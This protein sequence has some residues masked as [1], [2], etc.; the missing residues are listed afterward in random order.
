LDERFPGV[1]QL[2]VSDEQKQYTS[3]N[4][5][6]QEYWQSSPMRIMASKSDGHCNNTGQNADIETLPLRHLSCANFAVK[7]EAL[8]SARSGYKKVHL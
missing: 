7:V 2:H 4:N 5:S 6:K 3:F 1:Q 8:A